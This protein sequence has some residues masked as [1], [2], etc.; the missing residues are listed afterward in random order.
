[1][2]SRAWAGAVGVGTGVTVIAD[3]R[4]GGA[5]VV[6]MPIEALTLAA[7]PSAVSCT[8][9]LAWHVKDR[10]G[11]PADYARKIEAAAEELVI[12]AVAATGV[13]ET[14]PWHSP[15]FDNLQVIEV[16]I[17]ATRDRTVI[18]VRDRASSPPHHRLGA[19]T[20]IATAED[21]GHTLLPGGWRAVWCVV[22][23]NLSALAVSLPAQRLGPD[24]QTLRRVL[25]GLHR[26]L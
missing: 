9:M 12:H 11:L 3:H 19:S 22:A 24:T 25:D 10:G 21:W 26:R 7:L 13:S 5:H 15:V 8:R 23:D 20:A 18:E 4:L 16:S 1:M 6:T 14:A 17:H 2:G